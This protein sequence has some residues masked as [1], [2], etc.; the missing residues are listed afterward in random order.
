MVAT[1][2]TLKTTAFSEGY[3]RYP[4]LPTTRREAVINNIYVGVLIRFYPDLLPD[5]VG[6]NR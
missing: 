4:S 5:V 2:I 3:N 6:R 1:F